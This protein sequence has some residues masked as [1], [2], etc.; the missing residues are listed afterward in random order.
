MEANCYKRWVWDLNEVKYLVGLTLCFQ[1]RLTYS[2][3]VNS[4]TVDIKASSRNHLDI[5]R[6]KLSFNAAL[7]KM[8]IREKC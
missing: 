8:H 7:I 3:N 1:N 4:L 5:L 2:E 6:E